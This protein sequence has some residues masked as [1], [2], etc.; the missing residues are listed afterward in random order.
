MRTEPLLL[1][2]WG[3]NEVDKNEE[4]EDLGA[5]AERVSDSFPSSHE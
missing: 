4:I 5:W 1:S 3:E 2:L